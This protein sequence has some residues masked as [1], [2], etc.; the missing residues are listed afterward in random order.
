[1]GCS[2]FAYIGW[3]YEHSHFFADAKVGTFYACEG[4]SAMKVFWQVPVILAASKIGTAIPTLWGKY[5][6]TS[7]LFDLIVVAGM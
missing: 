2:F 6:A 3:K 7:S 1:M 4:L 5:I